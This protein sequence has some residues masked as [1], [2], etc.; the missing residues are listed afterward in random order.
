MKRVPYEYSSFTEPRSI[1]RLGQIG[2]PDE[3]VTQYR[4]THILWVVWDVE[5]GCDIHF[6]IIPK[7]RPMSGQSRSNFEATVSFKSIPILS[8]IVS[9]FKKRHLF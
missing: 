2:S 9:G 7:E 8:G 5:F 4:V 6:Q 3:N 1:P